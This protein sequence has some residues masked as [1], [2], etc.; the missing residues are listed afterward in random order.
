MVIR[1]SA[2]GRPTKRRHRKDHL[3]ALPTPEVIAAWKIERLL[4]AIADEGGEP[5]D[6]L[7]ATVSALLDRKADARS[8]VLELFEFKSRGCRHVPKVR[9]DIKLLTEGVSDQQASAGLED[10][11][12]LGKKHCQRKVEQSLDADDAV[13]LPLAERKVRGRALKNLDAQPTR[14]TNGMRSNSSA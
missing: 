11:S 7:E 2:S 5:A 10:A 3:S 8:G 9:L 14:A 4:Q 12:C 6:S 13:E 1:S